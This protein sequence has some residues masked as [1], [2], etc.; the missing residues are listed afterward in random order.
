MKLKLKETLAKI[1]QAIA[2]IKSMLS[3]P[4]KLVRYSAQYY[5][6]GW[7]MNFTL[8]V[9][10]GYTPIAVVGYQS[11]GSA[12][13]GAQLFDF[14]IINDTTLR[15]SC[16]SSASMSVMSLACRVLYVKSEFLGGGTA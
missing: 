2:S 16:N 6:N 9:Y 12:D 3:T 15:I 14:D 10:S 11:G 5:G 13:A 7:Y 1:L 8:P 4:F